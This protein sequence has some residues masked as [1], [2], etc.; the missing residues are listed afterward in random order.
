MSAVL[1]ETLWKYN[2]RSKSS[3]VTKD[4]L[5]FLHKKRNGARIYLWLWYQFL[6]HIY[7]AR[8]VNFQRLLIE[9][10]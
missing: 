3:N 2:S 10:Q 1:I 8:E 4:I 7:H 6:K 5:K 9:H